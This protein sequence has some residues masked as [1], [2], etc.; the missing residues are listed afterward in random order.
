MTQN[1]PNQPHCLK[2]IGTYSLWHNKFAEDI[3]QKV[4]HINYEIIFPN[5]AIIHEHM[6]HDFN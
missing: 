3:K 5:I 4:V 6:L 1:T 2:A